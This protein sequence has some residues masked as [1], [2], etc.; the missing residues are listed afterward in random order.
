MS[1]RVQCIFAIC[2]KYT[3]MMLNLQQNCRKGIIF[4][5]KLR[6]SFYKQICSEKVTLLYV[7]PKFYRVTNAGNRYSGV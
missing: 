7:A 4:I 2:C 3:K 5:T 6:V 1:K